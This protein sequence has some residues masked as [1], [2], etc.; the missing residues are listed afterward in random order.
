M[1]YGA[2]GMLT[3]T[4]NNVD[5]LLNG[6]FIHTI[7]KIGASDCP[8][9]PDMESFMVDMDTFNTLVGDGD[10]V[11]VMQSS[12]FLPEDC[13]GTTSI[14]AT[15]DYLAPTATP[16]VNA[17]GVPDEC[18][19][20]RGDFNLDGE[21]NVTDLLSLLAAWG[22]CPN[23][24]EDINDDGSVNVTDLLTLLAAWGA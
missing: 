22:V 21:V 1:S 17:N 18:D 24:I 5:I 19:L 8:L 23:C 2:V 20:A 9:V 12:N 16:D 15:V 11:L 6:T 3:F 13:E 4:F 14:T 7:F 10:A